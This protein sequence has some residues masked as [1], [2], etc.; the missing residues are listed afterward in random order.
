MGQ[1]LCAGYLEDAPAATEAFSVSRTS[2]ILRAR[3]FKEMAL[4]RS[5]VHGRAP[6][7]HPRAVQ[8]VAQITEVIVISDQQ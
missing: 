4:L 5:S 6:H 2:R 7:A 3:A 8:K 1:P